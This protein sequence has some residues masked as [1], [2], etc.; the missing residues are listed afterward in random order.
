MNS[1]KTHYVKCPNCGQFVPDTSVQCPYCQNQ[2][3]IKK[4]VYKRVWFIVLMVFLAI[5]VI[6]SFG[7]H[8]SSKKEDKTKTTVVKK[9]ENKK[10]E[11]KQTY[12]KDMFNP[13]HIEVSDYKDKSTAEYVTAFTQNINTGSSEMVDVITEAAIRRC[14][15]NDNEGYRNE[16]KDF[17]ISNFPNYWKDEQTMRQTIYY[18]YYLNKSYGDNTSLG[19]IG[20]DA[21]QIGKAMYRKQ[22]TEDSDFVQSN[23]IQIQKELQNYQKEQQILNKLDESAN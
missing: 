16:A 20:F 9:K 19:K 18:G 13:N 21:Y 7:E 12:D 6:G 17:I 14:N 10:T 23:L 2:L 15:Y 3:N 1:N 5:G 11:K 4:P 22:E 8:D